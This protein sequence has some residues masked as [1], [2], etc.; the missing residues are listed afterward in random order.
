MPKFCTNCGAGL[1]EGA[2]F[3]NK[4]GTVTPQTGQPGAAPPFTPPQPQ[5]SAYQP[6]S[7]S[8]MYQAPSAGAGLDSNVAAALSYLFSFITGIVF[9][10]I[11]PY[12]KDR[13]VRFHAFQSIFFGVAWIVVPMVL[14]IIAIPLPWPL[15]LFFSFLRSA[16]W[17]GF[18][19]VWLF[20]MYKAY[21]RERFKL[22]VIGDLAEKQAG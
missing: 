20:L 2:K 8:P 5:A 11:D 10:A 3:C 22:P 7:P 17:L 15:H 6:A 14:G 21:N 13:F 19:L 16:V 4:C 12:N 1:M 18:L 9:L